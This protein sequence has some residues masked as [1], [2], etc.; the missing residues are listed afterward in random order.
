MYYY[1]KLS[2]CIVVVDICETIAPEV[3]IIEKNK[4]STY[5]RKFA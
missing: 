4:S 1:Y 3:F 2:L 5:G